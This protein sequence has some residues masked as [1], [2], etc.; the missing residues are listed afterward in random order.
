MPALNAYRSR[1]LGDDAVLRA[2]ERVGREARTFGNLVGAGFP[3]GQLDEARQNFIQAAETPVDRH[4]GRRMGQ[5]FFDDEELLTVFCRYY[6]CTDWR[7][8]GSP[9]FFAKLDYEKLYHALTSPFDFEASLLDQGHGQERW[10][11]LF[12]RLPFDLAMTKAKATLW[13][14]VRRR[15]QYWHRQASYRNLRASKLFHYLGQHVQVSG[16]SRDVFFFNWEREFRRRLDAAMQTFQEALERALRRWQEERNQERRKSQFRYGHFA[17]GPMQ[18]LLSVREAML[19]LEVELES[20]TLDDVRRAFRRLSKA[21]H[22][23]QGGSDESFRLLAT[24]RE[25]AEAW[26]RNRLAS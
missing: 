16:F 24:C 1:V 22:P 26:I 3:P 18:P 8:E 9:L 19:R 23:D 21:A 5:G 2:L 11:H 20:A 6:G 10:A 17:D 12:L 25:V 15:E 13:D 4:A 14:D 7:L